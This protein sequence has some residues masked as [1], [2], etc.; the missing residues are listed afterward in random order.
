MTLAEADAG[1]VVKAKINYVGAMTDRPKFHA[2]DHRRDN[3]VYDPQVMEIAD[4]RSWAVPPS[5]EREGVQLVHA[6]TRVTDYR[7]SDQLKELYLQD[8]AELVRR[9]TGATEVHMLPGGGMVRYA[10]RS[11]YF[12]T[13]MNTLPARFPHID[14]TPATAPGLAE[15]TFG[16]SKLELKPGQRLIGYNVWRVFSPPPQNVP[17]AVLD[18]R[19]ITPEDLLKAD[20]VYDEGEDRSRWWELEAFVVRHNPRH[21]WIY[22]SNMTQDEALIFRAYDNAPQFRPGTAHS[23]FDDPNCPDDAPGRVSVEARAYAVFDGD[24]G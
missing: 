6:P 18:A 10:E 5:L 22:F 7:D 14:F 19:S 15:D 9:A 24:W 16:S 23:A 3:L 21:R 2:Q 13:G 20:G 11:P 4:A 12:G 17:L 1:T 8:T